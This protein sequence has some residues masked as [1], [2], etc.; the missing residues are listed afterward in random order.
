[1]KEM[2]AFGKGFASARDGG[3]AKDNP[4]KPATALGSDGVQ[5]YADWLDG[6]LIVKGYDFTKE[7]WKPVE[8]EQY[9]GS[10]GITQ[11]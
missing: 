8:I 3:K 7:P 11:I 10:V 5:Q 4:F 2:T 9:H 1:M 6:Y